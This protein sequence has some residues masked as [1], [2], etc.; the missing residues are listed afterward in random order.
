MNQNERYVSFL[1]D[2]C[3]LKT[4]SLYYTDSHLNLMDP[5]RK[6]VRFV[7]GYFLEAEHL[8]QSERVKSDPITDEST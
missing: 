2:L 6:Y 7:L 3:P 5:I 8:L 4:T 1:K